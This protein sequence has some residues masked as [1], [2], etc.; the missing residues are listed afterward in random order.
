MKVMLSFMAA[1][2][3]G[4]HPCTGCRFCAAPWFPAFRNVGTID[5]YGKVEYTHFIE[6]MR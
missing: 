6:E 3:A 5:F 1:S 2:G 4:I